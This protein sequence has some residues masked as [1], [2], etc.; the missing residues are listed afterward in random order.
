MSQSGPSRLQIVL[1]F[2]SIYL[3]WGSTYLGILYAVETIPP[4][5]LAGMR[6]IVASFCMWSVTWFKKEV[7][8]TRDEKR[9]AFISGTLMVLANGFVGVAEKHVSSGI[10]AVVIGAMP[11][12]V[13]LVG[14]LAFGTGRPEA[15]KIL[16]ACIGLSGIFWIA[17][18]G[19]HVSSDSWFAQA[20]PLFLCLSSI[21]W[22]IGTLVQRRLKG[23]T[24]SFKFS[25]L[26]MICGA[27]AAS[28]CSLLFESPFSYDW[29]TV[30]TKSWFAL[31][32]LI[33]FGSLIGFTAYTWLSRNVEPYLV[34]TYALVNPVIAVWLGWMLA[35]EPLTGKFIGSTI[36]VLLGLAV[37]MWRPRAKTT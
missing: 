19:S 8:L 30:T 36:L 37:L 34:S 27:G 6:F 3:V 4:W 35:D 26:Q 29:S 11:I 20:A 18:G 7:P 10:A 33:A 22:T 12:W 13:M 25:A 23:L 14:W 21:L 2:A 16:G 15:R 24:S 32:Y 31:A 1:A 5:A 17:A 28:L 9:I